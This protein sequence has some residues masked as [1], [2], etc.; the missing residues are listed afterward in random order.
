M[1]LLILKSKAIYFAARDLMC[2]FTGYKGP[3]TEK[4]GMPMDTWLN[5]MRIHLKDPSFH[6]DY[7]TN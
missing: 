7:E 4:D 6:T 1:S 5:K 3:L 2:F